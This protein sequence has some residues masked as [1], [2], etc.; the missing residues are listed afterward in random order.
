MKVHII[1]TGGTIDGLEYSAVENAPKETSNKVE[2]FL[3]DA[4]VSFDYSMERAFS[5]DSRFIDT[6]DRLVLANK[7]KTVEESKI[8][9]THG[10]LSMMETA[11]YLG[12]LNL[13]KTI[14]LVGSFILGTEVNTDA[15]FNLGYAL[16]ALQNLGPGVFIAMNGSVF[17]WD[18]VAKNTDKN[19]FEKSV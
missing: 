19:R 13:E 18:N 7:I 1:T 15:P 5:K 3:Q 16:S 8:L 11:K 10:T 6:E 4:R 9:I 17:S 12:A 2:Q 14:V